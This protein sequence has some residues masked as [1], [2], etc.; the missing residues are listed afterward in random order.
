[1]CQETSA[2]PEAQKHL[3]G[4]FPQSLFRED[5]SEA[6]HVPAV[7]YSLRASPE[8]E[9]H[10]PRNTYS[11]E[12]APAEVSAEVA[13][14]AETAEAEKPA[15]PAVEAEKPEEAAKAEEP[16]AETEIAYDENLEAEL[17]DDALSEKLEKMKS[18]MENGVAKK[19]AAMQAKVAELS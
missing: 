10:L 4:R 9:F 16:A 19:D 7:H 12:A 13:E 6:A 14:V 5:G 18:D 1:M 17:S 15:E 8:A 2:R 3:P 11:A